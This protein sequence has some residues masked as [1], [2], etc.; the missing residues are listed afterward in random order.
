MAVVPLATSFG[1]TGTRAIFLTCLTISIKWFAAIGTY[2]VIDS[3]SVDQLRVRVPP[4]Q[5]AFV[6]AKLFFALMR[7]A[8]YCLSAEGT[9]LLIGRVG[10]L[11]AIVF[12]LTDG[13]IQ[14][15]SD[16]SVTISLLLESNDF[17]FSLHFL[18][19]ALCVLHPLVGHFESGWSAFAE[20]MQKNLPTEEKSSVGIEHTILFFCFSFDDIHCGLLPHSTQMM[21][22]RD[23]FA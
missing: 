18:D 23:R 7:S 17:V 20:K 15:G 14:T 2:E 5:T 8:L 4:R 3:F 9:I 13:Q 21:D 1:I 16:F 19:L 22:G 11:F 10:V 12:D 6:R